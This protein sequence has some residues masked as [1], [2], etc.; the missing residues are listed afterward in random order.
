MSSFNTCSGADAC[1]EGGDHSH[2]KGTRGLSGVTLD[3][4]VLELRVRISSGDPQVVAQV[5]QYDFGSTALSRPRLLLRSL[6]VNLG[7]K[8]LIEF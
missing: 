4:K 8:P 7:H 1:P 6:L 5:Q 2:P 3:G